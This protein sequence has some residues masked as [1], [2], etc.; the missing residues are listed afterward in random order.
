MTSN[1]PCCSL[2]S[3]VSS[4]DLVSSV[5][6]S[7]VLTSKLSEGCLSSDSVFVKSLSSQTSLT[8]GLSGF[9]FR[10]PSGSIAFSSFFVGSS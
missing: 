3:F 1:T 8:K 5:S 7:V 4:L 9:S 6:S 10:S 2:F